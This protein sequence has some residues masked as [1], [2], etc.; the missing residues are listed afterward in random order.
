MEMMKENPFNMLINSGSLIFHFINEIWE[1][2]INSNSLCAKHKCMEIHVETFMARVTA[3][4]G[5]SLGLVRASRPRRCLGRARLLQLPS[6]L[7]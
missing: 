4:A 2:N 1:A 3:K 5:S 6:W 7:P